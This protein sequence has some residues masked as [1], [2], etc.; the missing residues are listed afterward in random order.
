MGEEIETYCDDKL[1]LL[2]QA[3]K[4][5]SSLITFEEYCLWDQKTKRVDKRKSFIKDVKDLVVSERSELEKRF[6]IQR[7]INGFD[8]DYSFFS[9]KLVS[10]M[11]VLREKQLGNDSGNLRKYLLDLLDANDL[12]NPRKSL[13]LVQEEFF[14]KKLRA[15][16]VDSFNAMAKKRNI[17]FE[18]VSL[19]DQGKEVIIE[20]AA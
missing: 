7:S 2:E 3:I 11:G 19:P 15:Q 10:Q 14:D 20:L 4:L 12:W 1:D 5:K 9:S 16:T 17:Q 18:L 6:N 13:L 8:V